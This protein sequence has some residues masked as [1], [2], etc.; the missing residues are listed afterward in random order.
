MDLPQWIWN[1]GSGSID[2]W[3]LINGSETMGLDQMI[4]DLDQWT[5]NNGCGSLD[6]DPLINASELMKLEKYI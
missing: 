1:I 4:M 6:L 3:I 5:W 2:Q